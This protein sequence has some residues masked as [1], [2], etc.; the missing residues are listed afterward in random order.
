VIE[1]RAGE[2]H[3]VISPDEGGRVASLRVGT[4]Q[5]LIERPSEVGSEPDPM[6]WGCYPMAPWA[7]RVRHGQFAF[8]GTAFQLPINFAPH[9]IHGTVF[10]RSWHVDLVEDSAATMSCTFGANWPFGGAVGQRIDLYP[11][12]LVC[13]LAITATSHEMPA[14]LGWHPWFVKPHSANLRFAKMYV[15][16]HEGIPSGALIEP[17][18]G[19][20][21]DCFIDPLEPIELRYVDASDDT[22]ILTI[23][24]DCN[25]WVVYDQPNHATCVEPQSGPPNAFNL[26]NGHTRSATPLCD[27]LKPGQTLRRSMNVRWRQNSGAR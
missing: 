24:S 21:D 9:A 18:I 15:R 17:G 8:G 10:T 4:R 22:F 26:S 25:H 12:R 27:V 5:L 3:C 6:S 2:A 14:E 23:S 1:L 7:G 16:D 11:D 20:W 19:P 13:E